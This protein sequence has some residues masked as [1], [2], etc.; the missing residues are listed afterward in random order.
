MDITVSDSSLHDIVASQL[1]QRFSNPQAV[2]DLI[3]SRLEARADEHGRL[4]GDKNNPTTLRWAMQEVVRTFV[5]NT[6]ATWLESH[7][8][9]LVTLIG[10][11]LAKKEV[12]QQI[13]QKTAAK[14]TLL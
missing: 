6:V 10:K 9:E 14:V 11:E 3:I 4:S 12:V 5:E 2:Q 8:D 7:H 1:A 13:A